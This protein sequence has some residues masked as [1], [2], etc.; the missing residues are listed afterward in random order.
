MDRGR[1][2]VLEPRFADNR[3]DRLPELAAELVRLNV[4]VIVTNGTLAP[5]AA[6]RVT[7]ST[8][9]VMIAAGD[10]AG[11]GLVSNLGR[12]GGNITGTSLNSPDLAGK[13]LQLLK[14]MIPKITTVAVIWNEA[15]PYPAVVFAQT[16]AAGRTLGMR[17]LSLS[18]HDANGVPIALDSALQGGAGT[19]CRRCMGSANT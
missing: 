1:T 12:P 7:S 16:E 17:I 11:S 2:F 9:I 4:D 14:E 13:R 6:K 19:G 10:P 3:P 18:V 15:N 8:P 5:L